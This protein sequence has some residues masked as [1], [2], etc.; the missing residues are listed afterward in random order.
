MKVKKDCYPI[1]M[2]QTT[3]D[4]LNEQEPVKI[5]GYEYRAGYALEAIDPVAFRIAVCDY[6]DILVEDGALIEID[7]KYFWA[8]DVETEGA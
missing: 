7:S 4:M 2:R 1:G 5:C 3:L 8:D 6:L